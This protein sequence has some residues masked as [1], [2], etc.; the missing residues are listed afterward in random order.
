MNVYM[1]VP[2]GTALLVSVLSLFVPDSVCALEAGGVGYNESGAHQNSA[3]LSDGVP[4]EFQL[5]EE[6]NYVVQDEANF[7][8]LLADISV[9]LRDVADVEGITR[10]VIGGTAPHLVMFVEGGAG[11]P[12][13]LHPILQRMVALAGNHQLGVESQ[14]TVL[15]DGSNLFGFIF[16][17]PFPTLEFCWTLHPYEAV[18]SSAGLWT[19]PFADLADIAEIET[20]G[21]RAS[22]VFTAGAASRIDRLSGIHGHQ[23]FQ[24]RGKGVEV[25]KELGAYTWIPGL[26]AIH[27]IQMTYRSGLPLPDGA[28]QQVVH[29]QGLLDRALIHAEAREVVQTELGLADD[30]S[31]TVSEKAPHFET[32]CFAWVVHNP[33]DGGSASQAPWYS[34]SDT[35]SRHWLSLAPFDRDGVFAPVPRHWAFEGERGD[36]IICRPAVDAMAQREEDAFAAFLR[37][38]LGRTMALMVRGQAVALFVPASAQPD[39]IAL[40]QLVDDDPR[41]LAD[42]WQPGGGVVSPALAQGAP[43]PAVERETHEDLFQVRLMAEPQDRKLIPVTHFAAPGAGAGVRVAV[44]N[45]VILDG[46]SVRGAQLEPKPDALYLRLSLTPDGREAL[47]GICF[48]NMGKQLAIIFNGRLL[49]APTIDDWE[50]YELVFKGLDADWS[51]VAKGLVSYLGDP[52]AEDSGRA[53]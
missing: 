1:R 46:R 43:A 28:P 53:L 6:N 20:S 21:E 50:H 18:D 49:S 38:N 24:L 5:V 45:E 34:T 8:P 23:R 39:A 40:T 37:R 25:P 48:S 52:P 15:D 29:L 36:R 47:D 33:I 12:G 14:R 11:T 2:Q 19:Q 44:Q 22:L 27:G 3:S 30:L 7:A 41:V 9:A 35:A 10:R 4:G 51:E 17:A 13:A 42:V 16:Y 32:P 26:R 31:W